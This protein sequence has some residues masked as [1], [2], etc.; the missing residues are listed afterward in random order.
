MGHDLYDGLKGN[1]NLF[2]NICHGKW[3]GLDDL[4]LHAGLLH[5]TLWV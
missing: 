3:E 4:A 5:L 2:V 1:I